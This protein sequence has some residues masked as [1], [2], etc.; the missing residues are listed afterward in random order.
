M[1]RKVILLSD[2]N[3]SSHLLSVYYEPRQS[4]KHFMDIHLEEVHQN[5]GRAGA[6]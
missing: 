1:I 6:P 4:A 3:S 2:D 5:V